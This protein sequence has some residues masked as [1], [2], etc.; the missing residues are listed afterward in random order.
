M[1]DIGTNP[2]TNISS[3]ITAQH[4]V[5]I[6]NRHVPT[7]TVTQSDHTYRCLSHL[8]SH[9]S[10]LTNLT[11]TDP[12]PNVKN[13]FASIILSFHSSPVSPGFMDDGAGSTRQSRRSVRK[14]TASIAANFLPMQA[15]GPTAQLMVSMKFN[16]K[17]GA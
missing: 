7:Q 11:G 16:L 8:K 10:L 17:S 13:I 3:L 4:S 9:F 2:N 5:Q 14:Q 1:T 12:G 6:V 15:R